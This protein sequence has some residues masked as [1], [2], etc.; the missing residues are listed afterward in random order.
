MNV[1]LRRTAGWLTIF[2]L[3]FLAPAASTWADTMAAAPMADTAAAMTPAPAPAPPAP[4]AAPPPPAPAPQMMMGQGPAP[5]VVP[6]FRDFLPILSRLGLSLAIL[7]V[8]FLVAKSTGKALGFAVE[9]AGLHEKIKSVVG[10]EKEM[11][12]D[13]VNVAS[14]IGYW[15]IM[16]ITLVAFF[17]ALG[18]S[19]VTAPLNQLLVTVLAFLPRLLAASILFLIAL[20]IATLASRGLT[21]ALS[22]SRATEHL[23][24]KIGISGDESRSHVATLGKLV[25]GLVLLLFL[26]QIL[27]AL[28]MQG[29]LSPVQKV[30]DRIVLI[31]PNLLGAG[32]LLL[33]GWFAA[34]ILREL[35]T[36]LLGAS[37]ID[38]YAQKAGLGKFGAQPLSRLAGTLVYTL[39]LIPILTASLEALGIS[40]IS[41]P[42]TRMLSIVL[43]AVPKV[44][45]ASL[46]LFVSWVMARLV[47]DLVS[48]LLKAAG[49]DGFLKELGLG[50]GKKAPSDLAG[51]LVLVG[52]LLF[53]STEAC[54]LL[55]FGIVAI[56][57]AQFTTFL[58]SV[59]LGAAVLVIGL[60]FAR[61]AHTVVLETGTPGAA[62]TA[63]VA[64]ITIIIFASAMALR[65]TG[66]A[67][68]IVNM[69]FAFLLGTISVAT[70]LAFGLGCR[71]LAAQATKDVVEQFKK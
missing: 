17:G 26:P 56:L 35:T 16:L 66:I 22:A 38:S 57:I 2:T 9:K 19:E 25:H 27:D 48:N 59:A 63:Q 1:N 47:A 5:Q 71:D 6:N 31:I 13:T 54:E 20:I 42:A 4:V 14:E 24:G 39:V 64:R 67:D 68:D 11:F 18:I 50:G 40:A 51:Y 44:V 21:A 30:V 3:L 43:G 32:L 15:V 46:V 37:G 10:G 62:T 36:G 29:L 49:F 33:I 12:F 70:A 58:G 53:A 61:I 28:S 45:G 52:I 55:G 41:D 7:I 34:K 69:A 60:F 23:L 8:G 65:Q